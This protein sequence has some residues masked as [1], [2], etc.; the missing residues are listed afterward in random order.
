MTSATTMQSE[1]E[2]NRAIEATI[3]KLKLQWMMAKDENERRKISEEIRRRMGSS[4]AK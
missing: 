3:H 2:Q 1:E 4:P